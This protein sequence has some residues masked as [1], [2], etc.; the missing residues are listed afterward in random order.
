MNLLTI[1]LALFGFLFFIAA[2]TI[3]GVFT[4]TY[5]QYKNDQR[6]FFKTQSK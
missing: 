5:F 4:Y 6:K 1:A 3:V 2:I